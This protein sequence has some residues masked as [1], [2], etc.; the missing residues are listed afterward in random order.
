MADYTLSGSIE[1]SPG[2]LGTIRVSRANR[3]TPEDRKEVLG[4][5]PSLP[6]LV[7]SLTVKTVADI[8]AAN[9]AEEGHFVIS[10]L[11]TGGPGDTLYDQGAK[12]GSIG[13]RTLRDAVPIYVFRVPYENEVVWYVVIDGNG[14]VTELGFHRWDGET[15][16]PYKTWP[17]RALEGMRAFEVLD[18]DRIWEYYARVIG[19]TFTQWMV[20]ARAMLDFLD[21]DR[22][23]AELLS[24]LAGNFGLSLD[25]TEQE[26]VQRQKIKDAIP[27]YKLKGL[28]LAVE[29]RLRSLGYTGYPREIWVNPDNPN[30]WTDDATGE[31]GNDW[32]EVIHGSR[33]RA[34]RIGLLFVGAEQ[35][36]DGETVVIDD[37]TTTVTFGFGS[38]GDVTVTIG[39]DAY[40]TLD[41][42]I[43]AINGSALTVEASETP[44]TD[45]PEMT[46]DGGKIGSDST[47]IHTFNLHVPSSRISIH[48]NR[49]G[50][51]PLSMTTPAAAL[52]EFKEFIAT[53][54][55]E[56]VLPAPIDIRFFATDFEVGP[57]GFGLG[58]ELEARDMLTLTWALTPTVTFNSTVNVTGSGT[59]F[60]TEI[61]AGDWIRLDSFGVWMQ[62]ESV[63]DDTNLVLVSAYPSS[64]SGASSAKKEI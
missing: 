4:Y 40:E 55:G 54:L 25:A 21:P 26:E 10:P 49:I 56:D 44:L 34:P 60:T 52:L 18:P 2:L 11:F 63:T 31:K 16:Q 62:V 17:E 32:I 19:A 58:E 35:P 48:I 61:A 15:W 3:Y 27:T 1:I 6:L 5:R 46:L 33:Y 29:L 42:L 14:D 7:N 57:S 39:A 13:T 53:Q 50:G 12:P 43:A 41:N 24:E 38:G 9:V 28:V 51:Q 22:C 45:W 47:I 64:G 59:L 20:D 8:T 23:P 36:F 30:N 37:Y